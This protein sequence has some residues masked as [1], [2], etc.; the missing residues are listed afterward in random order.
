MVNGS[1]ATA[2]DPQNQLKFGKIHTL[3]WSKA[4][5]IVYDA[6]E[7]KL[8]RS[9]ENETTGIFPPGKSNAQDL[10]NIYTD[11]FEAKIP[12]KSR[13]ADIYLEVGDDSDGDPKS[14]AR[15]FLATV[16]LSTLGW[17]TQWKRHKGEIQYIYVRKER[18]KL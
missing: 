15:A 13:R 11:C 18:K 5:V 4:T 7:Q 17:T 12:G 6:F 16:D 9:P 14:K 2:G 10:T 1:H 8:Y 3:S